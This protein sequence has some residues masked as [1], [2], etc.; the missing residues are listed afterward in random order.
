VRAAEFLHHEH[1][2]ELRW[3][4]RVIGDI[5][6]LAAIILGWFVLGL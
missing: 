3:T 4:R 5:S 6:T 1:I 2:N